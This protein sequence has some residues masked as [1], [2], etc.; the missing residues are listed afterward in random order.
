MPYFVSPVEEDGLALLTAM[1]AACF[2]DPWSRGAIASHLASAAGIALIA[3]DTEGNALGYLLGLSLSGE[4]EL[5]RIAVLPEHR[6][7][8]VGL[9]L[10]DGFLF[11]LRGE[12][13]TSC[14]LEVRRS[15]VGA[16][17]LYEGAGFEAVGERKHYYKNPTEDAI[18][19]ARHLS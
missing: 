10:L 2:S 8:G 6:L 1:E 17:A 14:F 5:L 18:L 16:I 13:I 7:R 4:A 15:N 3:R 9:E 19:M 11:R 12:G